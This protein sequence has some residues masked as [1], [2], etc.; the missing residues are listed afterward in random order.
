MFSAKSK[1]LVFVFKKEKI[2]PLHMLFVFYPI[3]VLFLDKNKKIVEIKENFRP[4]EFYTPKKKSKYVI[5]L[6]K[7]AVK[8]SKT[9]VGD[10]IRF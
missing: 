8:R 6:A 7:G 2:N 10:K 9:K 3:D 4:F 1:N 5:E